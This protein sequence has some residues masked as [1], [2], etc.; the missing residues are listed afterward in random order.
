MEEKPI[1]EVVPA[2]ES[3]AL[4]TGKQLLIVT[5]TQSLSPIPEDVLGIE[6]RD[7]VT[8]ALTQL[9]PAT[10]TLDHVILLG[11]QAQEALGGHIDSLLGMVSKQDAP[12]L[13]ALLEKLQ[14]GLKVA[15]LEELDAAM[16]AKPGWGQ[17]AL[18]LVGLSDP[19]AR[20]KSIA[21]SVRGMLT[22]KSKSLLD[23]VNGME[24]EARDEMIRLMQNLSMLDQL[25]KGYL[26][27]VRSFG[28]ATALSYELL[29]R[30]RSHERLLVTQ[31]NRTSDPQ[32][33]AAARNYS[34]L[35]EQLQN[36]A[37]TLRTA[38]ESVPGEL[39][40]VSIAKGA[41]ATTLAETAN[42]LRQEFN[43]M[44]S[45]LVKWYVLLTIQDMQAGNAR[46]REI[47][48][49]LRK[50]NVNVLDKVSTHAATMQADNRVEDAQL[51][52]GIAKGLGDLRTKLEGLAE[53]RKRKFQTAETALS[54]ARSIFNKL[55]AP[56]K[57]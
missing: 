57:A 46:R 44:K 22:A 47:T 50:H 51:L 15:N 32:D 27:S 53:E 36:R 39:E 16:N 1:T 24:Q 56:P 3:T 54:Q 43:D 30:V 40:I 13:Y 26:D 49:M 31:A 8:T 38:Y 19:V 37:L 23:L 35:V 45:A 41:A 25:G 33:I 14:N 29:V 55:P 34:G 9:D 7:A 5:P 48:A 6:G 20:L 52:L 21:D 4:T 17:W 18:E 28:I 2:T 10:L 42:G 11:T 12:A